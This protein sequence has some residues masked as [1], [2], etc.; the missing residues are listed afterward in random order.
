MTDKGLDKGSR[1]ERRFAIL[2]ALIFFAIALFNVSRHEMWRDET[3]SWQIAAQSRTLVDLWHN[4][5]Y[6]GTPLLWYLILW[7]L[8][9]IT[10]S[11]L[12]MQ[13]L[14]VVIAAAVVLL[15]AWRAPFGRLIKSL[16]TFG[17]FPFFEY[18]T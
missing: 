6:E 16:F 5:R 9:K 12:A 10:W 11:L 13:V 3:R 18:A 14:H 1:D 15:F 4:L 7:V 17:Y 2:L 8:T